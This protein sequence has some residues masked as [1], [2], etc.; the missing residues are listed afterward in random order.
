VFSF[1]IMIIDAL[2]SVF[3]LAVICGLLY[4]TY[5]FKTRTLIAE[6]MKFLGHK[7]NLESTKGKELIF[8]IKRI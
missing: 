4:G 3:G 2:L 8:T 7:F 6:E 1:T 5:L